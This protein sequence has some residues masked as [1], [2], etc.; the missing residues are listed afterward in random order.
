MRDRDTTA[1]ANTEPERISRRLVVLGGLLNRIGNFGQMAS[2]QDRLIFQK[3]TY[4]LQVF[5]LYLGYSFSWYLYGPYSPALTRDG[6]ELLTVIDN[7]PKFTFSSEAAEARFKKFL[8]FLGSRQRDAKWLETVASVHSLCKLYPQL[9][10]T[11]IIERVANKQ[12]YFSEDDA[13]DA[14]DH[15]VA[16]K[17][18]DDRRP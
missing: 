1:T 5:G 18:I 15:L 11:D 10:R 9:S 13:A 14:W 6:Y 17:L 2:F 7:L 3:T 12:P 8:E 16:Y 4:L